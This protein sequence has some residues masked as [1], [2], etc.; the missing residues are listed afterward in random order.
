MLEILLIV[1]GLLCAA[2]LIDGRGP[3]NAPHRAV[4]LFHRS[5]RSGRTA[6]IADLFSF[7]AAYDYWRDVTASLGLGCRAEGEF[8]TMLSQRFLLDEVRS[9]AASYRVVAVRSKILGSIAG[10]VFTKVKSS[11]QR[12]TAVATVVFEDGRWKVRTFPGVFP[13]T[14]LSEVKRSAAEALDGESR[15]Q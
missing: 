10:V 15:L 6:A 8:Q 1:L 7:R 9:D 11:G 13:G 4:M 3:G 5:I 12:E 14:L 2:L